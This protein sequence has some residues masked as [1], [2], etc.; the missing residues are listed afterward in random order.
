MKP[1]WLRLLSVL[2][3]LRRTLN[4]LAL[5]HRLPPRPITVV[6][7]TDASGTTQQVTEYLAADANAWTLGS[8][9]TIG[10]PKCVVTVQGSEGVVSYVA[11][12]TLSVGC[13]PPGPHAL[14][15]P[16]G[17]SGEPERGCQVHAQN[18]GECHF[19]SAAGISV[20]AALVRA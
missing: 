18:S 9:K 4:A 16:P 19:H 20:R 6:V 15:L 10:W 14:P 12:N 17:S 5:P 7:R 13:A 11:A 8:G 1:C 3:G 2:Q